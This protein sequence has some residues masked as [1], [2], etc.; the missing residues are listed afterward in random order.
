MPGNDA[1]AAK[2]QEYAAKIRAESDKRL[3]EAK[4]AIEAEIAAGT[5]MKVTAQDVL[6]RAGFKPAF[7]AKASRRN[8]N[9]AMKLWLA[10]QN[11][12]LGQASR[13]RPVVSDEKQ[14]LS[15]LKDAF[16]RLQ[17]AYYTDSLTGIALSRDLKE[18][19]SKVARLTAEVANLEARLQ[20]VQSSRPT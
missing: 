19:R 8:T 4:L 5:L 2:G 3:E 14:L 12:R 11:K 16:V 20:A 1:I 7:L 17:N 6:R 13:R 18:E 15:D 9:E 10:A